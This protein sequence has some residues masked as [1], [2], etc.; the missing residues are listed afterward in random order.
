VRIE[1]A[2][3]KPGADA[4]EWRE[5]AAA[6]PVG[7][8]EANAVVMSLLLHHLAPPAKRAA[9]TEARRVLRPDGAL[10]VADWGTPRGALPRGGFALLRLIDGL[11]GTRDHGAGLLPQRIEE[12]GFSAPRVW[13]RLPTV[14]G[15][16]ELLA[17][18]PGAA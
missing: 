8:A 15:T 17:A 4:V 11:E 13:K 12:A 10:V 3:A 6:L 14:W 16:L 18:R 2:R 1:I 5:A 7:D 9:L